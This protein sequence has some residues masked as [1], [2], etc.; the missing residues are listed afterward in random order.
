MGKPFGCNRKALL[1]RWESRFVPIV[2]SLCC[3]IEVRGWPTVHCAAPILARIA[4][5]QPERLALSRSE[6]H[7]ALRNAPEM[8][9]PDQNQMLSIA[10]VAWQAPKVSAIVKCQMLQAAQITKVCR[11]AR[12][13]R[14]CSDVQLL[15]SAQ[16]AEAVWKA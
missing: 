6:L 11:Q 3:D 2:M 9:T 16:A 5:R 4:S 12:Q 10:E 8:R 13:L 14:P 1:L 15:Q 7:N